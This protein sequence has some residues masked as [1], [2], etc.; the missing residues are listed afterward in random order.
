MTKAAAAAT[1]AATLGV[2]LA[3]ASFFVDI[4]KVDDEKR[5]VYGYASTLS[6]DSQG[7]RVTKSAMVDAVDDYMKFANIREMHQPSA[8]GIAKSVS[9]DDTG[10]MIEAHIVDDAA[11]KKVKSGVYKG[12]SI[13]G[14]STAK[15]DGVIS[16]MKL[17]EISLVDRPANPECVISLWKGDGIELDADAILKAAQREAVLALAELLDKGTADPVAL[18]AFAKGE[19]AAGL[20]PTPAPTAEPT[21]APAPV[22]APA[23]A[24]PG[25]AKAE[26]AAALASNF[27][28][29]AISTTESVAIAK[30]MGTSAQLAMLLKQLGSLVQNQNEEAAREKDNSVVPS[31]LHDLLVQGGRT[32]V[33]M[34]TEEVAE[35]SANVNPDSPDSNRH[36]SGGSTMYYAAAGGDIAKRVTADLAAL[37]AERDAAIGKVAGLEGSVA[38]IAKQFTELKARFD[39]LPA[40]PRGR[41]LVIQK[42]D[43]LGLDAVQAAADAATVAEG[44]PLLKADGTVDHEGTALAQIRKLHADGGNAIR[45]GRPF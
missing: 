12:F 15:V 13:G 45:M 25:V 43:D 14:K 21:A 22:P 30:G 2:G 31:M 6:L 34:V 28:V 40:Q 18:L 23:A 24:T 44:K 16:G 41:L 5:L 1:L 17:S 36:V 37:T 39:K 20:A 8:V 32:L 19:H 7:E 9:V 27:E 11:W 35:M 4:N 29:A 38:D 3:H 42:G 26:G 10:M 33:A